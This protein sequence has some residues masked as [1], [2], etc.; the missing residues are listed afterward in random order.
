MGRNLGDEMK[1]RVWRGEGLILVCDKSIHSPE[2]VDF[3]G[4]N[5][6]PIKGKDREKH[7]TLLPGELSSGGEVELEKKNQW[8]LIKVKEDV[9]IVGQTQQNKHPVLTWRKYGNGHVLVMA[10]PLAFKAGTNEIAQL[11]LNA[12]NL[13]SKDVYSSSDLTRILPIKLSITNKASEEKSLIVKEILPY[14]VEGYDYEPEPEEGEDLKWNLKVPGAGEVKISYWLRLPDQINIYDIKTEIYEGDTLRDELSITFEVSQTVL[15]RLDELIVEIESMNA[16]GSDARF[17]RKVVNKLQK[18]RDRTG[19]SLSQHLVNLLDSVEA[20]NNLGKVKTLDV[21]SQRLNT[22]N[23][24]IIMGRRFYEKVKTWGA[25]K[26]TPFT[27]MI[28]GD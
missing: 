26:L 9:M 10:V 23:I 4:V 21:S 5:V 22:Q 25:S 11:L 28:T 12:V 1:E 6:H 16:A 27:H 13:F 19:D 14:G 15:S 24:M 2:L 18:I 20:A 7:I 8:M 3:L 17:L